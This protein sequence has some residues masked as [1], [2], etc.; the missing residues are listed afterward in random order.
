MSARA[1]AR[2]QDP[3]AP[4]VAQWPPAESASVVAPPTEL[5][6]PQTVGTSFLAADLG[7]AGGV[8][9]PDASGDV[10]P[11]QV[12]V[13]VNGRVRVFAKDGTLGGL[14]VS[15]DSFFASV[16]NGSVTRDPRVRYDR[17]SGRWFVV[18][19]NTVAPNRILIAVSDGPAIHGQSSFTFFQFST[20]WSARS[21]TPTPEDSST[22]PRWVWTGTRC[23]SGG[24]QD[25]S[26]AVP[27]GSTA[28]V[29]KK[30]GAPGGHAPGHRIPTA[31]RFATTNGPFAPQGVDNDD[32]NASQGYFVGV[33]ALAFSRLVIRR[34]T[35]PAA[36]R[37]C[38]G[39]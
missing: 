2:K 35:N 6:A 30:A 10:G 21:P 26:G 39:T 11:A 14:D 23:T 16:R 17:L 38:R 22:T 34:V 24:T 20:T 8:V 7:A 12:L 19:I 25:A 31:Q 36:R 28:F 32:P 37:P 9:P 1:V 27:V 5:V 33:D 3:S 13:A 29:V 15:L 4:A 18:A